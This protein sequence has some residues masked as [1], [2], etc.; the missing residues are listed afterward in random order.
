MR[1]GWKPHLS[2]GESV[3]LFL[4]FTIIGLAHFS[5]VGAG[6]VTLDPD[7]SGMPRPDESGQAGTEQ[8]G[9]KHLH[10]GARKPL[11][12]GKNKEIFVSLLEAGGQ[13]FDGACELVFCGDYDLNVV[14]GQ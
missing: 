9:C 6:Q 8:A 3:Y 5:T 4:V 7:L 10:I 14:F 1:C 13:Q 12:Q 2:R 11:L